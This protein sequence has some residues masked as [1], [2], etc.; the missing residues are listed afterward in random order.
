M[1]PDDMSHMPPISLTE[2]QITLLDKVIEE[3]QEALERQLIKRATN[4][5]N[6]FHQPDI[7]SETYTIAYLF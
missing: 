4:Y 6:A 5:W 1:S 7:P 2:G 3:L